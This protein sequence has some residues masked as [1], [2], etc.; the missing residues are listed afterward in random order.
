MHI[1]QHAWVPSIPYL[2]QDV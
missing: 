2:R 1:K